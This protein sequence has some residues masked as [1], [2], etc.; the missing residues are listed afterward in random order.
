[1]PIIINGPDEEENEREQST[2]TVDFSD[3]PYVRRKDM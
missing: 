3:P 1:M 2:P